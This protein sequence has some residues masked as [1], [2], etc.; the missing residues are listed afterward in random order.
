MRVR[1][2]GIP[3]GGLHDAGHVFDRD[4]AGAR[5]RQCVGL[6]EMRCH[7]QAQ[8]LRL[9]DQRPQQVRRDLRVDLEII[10]AGDGMLID[11]ATRLIGR[12]DAGRV[13]IGRR[14]AVDHGTRA[15]HAR[16]QDRSEIQV[17]LER[18]HRVGAAVQIA[19]RRDAPRDVAS[20]RPP[21][22]VCVRVDQTR[23]DGFADQIDPLG[24]LGNRDF[25]DVGNRFDMPVADDDDHVG[26]RR[27]A[28]AVDERRALERNDAIA[29]DA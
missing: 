28:R 14:R 7:R 2:G 16:A 12:R 13:G 1:V 4:D 23:D 5:R 25:V 10:H 6:A 22:H 20:R 15:E 3:G 11:R 18:E 29:G 26:L 21:F 17:V 24:A 8:L 27:A 9:V 19:H